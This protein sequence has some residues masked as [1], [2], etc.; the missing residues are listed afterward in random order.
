M[1]GF[2]NAPIVEKRFEHKGLPCV[3]LFN[4]P[5]YRNGY[6]GVP[7]DAEINLTKIECHGGIDAVHKDLPGQTD[8]DFWWIGFSCCH[9]GDGYDFETAKE[10]YFMNDGEMKAI[11]AMEI[12]NKGSKEKP[13]T[14]QF[15]ETECM[16]VAEQVRKAVDEHGE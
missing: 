16:R 3:I 2:I 15:C 9:A 7:I 5:G 6:V 4:S 11:K 13:K 8:E 10:K 1:S 14:L 12:A